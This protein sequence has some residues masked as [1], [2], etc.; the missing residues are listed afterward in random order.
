MGPLCLSEPELAE[1][2]PT[3]CDARA[4]PAMTTIDLEKWLGRIMFAE[5]RVK[6]RTTLLVER[7]ARDAL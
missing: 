2:A 7:R 1:Q 5:R 4:A 3:N 6:A